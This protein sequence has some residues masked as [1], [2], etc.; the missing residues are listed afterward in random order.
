MLRMVD[1][2]LKKRAGSA[3]TEDEISFIIGGTMNDSIPDYQLSAWLMAVC[4][5]GMNIDETAYMTNALLHSGQVLD[6]SSI[7]PIVGDKHSTGGVGDKTTLVL[8]PLLSAAGLP[9]AKL[10]GRALGHTGGTIDKLEAIPGFRTELSTQEF[11]AQIK[12]IGLAICG[13]TA[14]LAPADGRLYALRDVTGTVESVPLIASSILS[15]KF[16]AGTNLIILDVKCGSGAFM[17]SESEAK[18]LAQTMEEVGKRLKRPVTALV[19]NMDQP[20][21]NAI[22]NTLEIIESIETLQGKGPKDLL[23]LCL[24][25]GSLALVKADICKTDKEAHSKLLDVIKNGQA[26]KSLSQMIEAQGG[27]CEVINDFSLMPT[28]KQQTDYYDSTISGEQ[29][30]KTLD[31]KTVAEACKIMGAGRTRKGESINLAVGIKLKAKVGDKVSSQKPLATI[32]Y[33]TT[34]QFAAA[35]Q[36]LEKAFQF[37]KTEIIPLPVVNSPIFA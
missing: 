21:G 12:K 17:K 19:T 2:I 28:A 29:W 7:G 34:E 1:L 23:E 13:Q 5:K 6:L 37:S 31:A 36:I 24:T 8:I 30:L 18:A 10:S 33:D 26:L 32:Y 14:D 15:K 11:V 3:H 20:L 35:S 9:M 22:G 16:A 25:F 4:L 27:N